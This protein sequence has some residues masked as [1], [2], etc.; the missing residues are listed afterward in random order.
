MTDKVTI[1]DTTL[2]DG[3]QS[4]GATMFA[5]EKIALAQMLDDM[6]VDVIEAGFA[7]ASPG[8]LACIQDVSRHVRNATICS[9]SRGIKSDIDASARALEFAH[10]PRI[11]TFISTSD[12]HIIHQFRMSHDQ[13]L[14]TIDQTVRYARSFC[15]DVEWSA[16]DATRSDMGFL[17]KAVGT[18]VHAGAQTINIPDTVGYTTSDEYRDI[19]SGL[20]TAYPNTIFSV[21]CH[22]DL[23][24]ATANSL[25]GIKGGARQIECT[26]NGIG[27]R[28]GN[29]ALEEV[30]MALKTRSDIYGCHTDIDT[31]RI[32]EISR[33]ASGMTGFPVQKNKAIVGWNAF[34]H[35]SGIHQDGVLKNPGTYEIM[36]S[37]SVGIVHPE[38]IMGKH[39]GRA[40]LENWSQER[41]ITLSKDELNQAFSV[42]KTIADSKKHVSESDIFTAVQPSSDIAHHLELL[43][44][45]TIQN[46]FGQNSADVSV[47]MAGKE[48]TLSAQG[49]GPVDAV[50]QAIGTAVPGP[51]PQVQEHEVHG[52]SYHEHTQSESRVT[53]L[54]Q[55]KSYTGHAYE[56]DTLMASASAY[57][58]AV[59]KILT[60]P[61][62]RAKMEECIP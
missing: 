54:Y 25:A 24:M 2:R 16:M 14:E 18:A 44:V 37:E 36:T 53:I 3:E 11:H 28:A 56:P 46:E 7:A 6:G 12:M 51:A 9:L 61:E 19:I 13:V 49:H 1:F 45:Q 4:P 55:N 35:E 27:E 22:N 20:V 57:I 29:A 50:F 60:Q 26:I 39:S 31:R 10:K 23:G 30:V 32:Y 62:Y 48:I 8:D 47:I 5:K 33:A 15:D 38:M 43:S 41:G 59:N 52:V 42:F 21:H 34:R 40:A 58:S 17:M